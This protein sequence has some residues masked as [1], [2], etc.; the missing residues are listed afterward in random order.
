MNRVLFL[1]L[2]SINSNLEN[3]AM[4]ETVPVATIIEAISNK[5]LDY[6]LLLAAIGTLSMAFIELIKGLTAFRRHFHR[7]EL[8]QWMP[9][10]DTRSE[11]LVLAAGGEQNAG[12]LFDQPTERMLGQIQAAANLSLEYP[13]H[14]P[15]AYAFFT[16]EDLQL[17][18]A[19]TGG[20]TSD[21]ELWENFATRTAREGYTTDEAQQLKQESEGRA[22]QQARAR[23]GNLIA[24][25]LDMF[26][27]RTQYRWARLNQLVSIIVGATLAAYALLSTNKIDNPK[28]FIA[29]VLLSLLAGMLAPFAKDV[30]AAISGLRAKS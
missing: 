5:T 9:D 8:T 1:I 13:D 21:S 23:L 19:R 12:V 15:H 11:L 3:I 20:M 2:I 29:L 26:Q 18:L 7:R 17:K 6:A 25:R 28:D 14:Y 24:R 22:A 16:R 27:N 4:T 10:H 30:V